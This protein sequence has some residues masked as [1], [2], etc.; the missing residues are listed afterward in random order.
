[1]KAR[2]TRCIASTSSGSMRLRDLGPCGS[3]GN[4]P[5][6]T[7]LGGPETV[8]QVERPQRKSVIGYTGE[9]HAIDEDDVVEQEVDAECTRPFTPR[10]NWSWIV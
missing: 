6:A 3:G 2:V 9:P 4:R 5:S 1:M 10:V 8:V 7:P